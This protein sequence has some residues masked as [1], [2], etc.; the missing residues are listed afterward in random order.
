MVIDIRE[1]RIFP[2]Q[3]NIIENG[4]QHFRKIM[5]MRKK[6]WLE[7]YQYWKDRVWL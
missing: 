6:D 3:T 5:E 2:D 1:K 4:K 7:E